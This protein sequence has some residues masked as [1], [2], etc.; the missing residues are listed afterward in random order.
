MSKLMMM[1]V[2]RSYLKIGFQK[3]TIKINCFFVK[4][5]YLIKFLIV[6]KNNVNH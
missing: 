5:L 2:I 4:K 6:K 1:M 3:K